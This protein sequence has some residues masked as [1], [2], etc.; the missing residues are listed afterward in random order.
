MD[1]VHRSTRDFSVRIFDADGRAVKFLGV[2]ANEFRLPRIFQ[3]IL[4][5][6]IFML[7]IP[8]TM[9]SRNTHITE[10]FLPAL[11]MLIIFPVPL[12]FIAVRFLSLT[13]LF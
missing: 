10:T 9:R 13:S 3:L 4:I 7:Q 12:R 11:T 5:Q 1:C 2:G 8:W 6:E